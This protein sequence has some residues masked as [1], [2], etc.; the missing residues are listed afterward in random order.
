MCLTSF[1]I[2][3]NL[4]QTKQKHN[5][6]HGGCL[7]AKSCLT[8]CVLK[9]CSLPGFSVHGISQARKLKKVAISSFRGSFPLRD[10]T[11]SSALTSGFFTAEPQGKPP[12][13][14]TDTHCGPTKTQRMKTQIHTT[15]GVLSLKTNA[16][17]MPGVLL[18]YS[19]C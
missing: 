19:G 18:G 15:P 6:I 3:Q 4:K 7:V 10:T 16:H 14:V 9:D 13:M 2:S 1:I 12:Y 5:S 8:L 17:L 11:P